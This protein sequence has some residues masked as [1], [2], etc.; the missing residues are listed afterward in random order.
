MGHIDLRDLDDDDLDAI[1]DLLADPA[2]LRPADFAADGAT[3]REAFDEWMLHRRR[4]A[5]VVLSVVTEDGGFAGLA[6]SVPL[7][8]ARE[9]SVWIAGHAAGR[10]VGTTALRLLVTREAERPLYAR[11][12]A[13][14]TASAALLT[15][16]GFTEVDAT[17][18]SAEV[19]LALPPTLE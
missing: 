5:E 11:I 13:A 1:F 6:A 4:D 18:S 3:D 15:K 19:V 14:D 8:G 7:E 12:A 9:I 16:M 10:D 2:A 17:A